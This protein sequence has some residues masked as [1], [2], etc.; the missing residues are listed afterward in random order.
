MTMNNYGK[1]IASFRPYRQALGIQAALKE[2]TE[3]KETLYDAQ[4]VDAC[5]NLF[6]EKSFSFE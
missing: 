1:T 5:L 2:I 4:V 3:E 6:T